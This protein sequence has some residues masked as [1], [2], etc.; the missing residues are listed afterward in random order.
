MDSA[1]ARRNLPFL[2]QRILARLATAALV[3]PPLCA[4]FVRLLK[5]A[6]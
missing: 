5:L 6:S 3:I 4:Q 2:L 1:G